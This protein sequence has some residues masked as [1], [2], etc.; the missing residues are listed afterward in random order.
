MKIAMLLLAAGRGSRFG[1]PVPKAWL[2]LDGRSLLVASTERLMAALP[3]DAQAEVLVLVHA[4]DRSTYV[5]EALPQLRAVLGAV[6]FQLVDGGATRQQSMANGLA[7]CHP[8]VDLVL[9][10]DVA[11]ALLPIAA[12]RDCIL[13]A[14]RTGAALLALPTPDTLKKVSGS[15]VAATLDRTDVWQAQTPQVIR[16]DLLV[17]AVQHAQHTGFVGTDDVS[18]VEHLGEAVAVVRGSPTNL[19]IT[20]P[21]DLP[22]AHAIQA[23]NL[24]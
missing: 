17:R 8:N 2:Q 4:D 18:L 23:A 12:T 11:R 20:H 5:E 9:V 14:A 13:A 24:A 7:A 6:P 19:K 3:A 10:H 1:G 15:R 16:R 22:L 21:D